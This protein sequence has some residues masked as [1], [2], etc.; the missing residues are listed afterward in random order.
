MDYDTKIDND[1]II[2]RQDLP[3]YES[4]RLTNCMKNYLISLYGKNKNVF[5]MGIGGGGDLGKYLHGNVKYLCGVEPSKKSIDSCNE[6]YNKLNPAR[7]YKVDFIHSTFEAMEISPSM[8]NNF[9]TV[10]SNFMFHYLMY[11]NENMDKVFEKINRLL[12]PGG[13]LVILTTD[14]KTI[15]DKSKNSNN[16]YFKIDKVKQLTSDIIEYNFSLEE[17]LSD[18]HEYATTI[19]NLSSIANK[20]KLH[21]VLERNTCDILAQIYSQQSEFIS[22]F[23]IPNPIDINKDDLELLSVYSVLIFQKRTV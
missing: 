19:E 22:K 1:R 9:D 20:H 13:Y 14:M 12:K 10:I 16:P 6:R 15:I 18:S 5:D 8:E 21:L 17:K 11:S 23:N 3:Y 4:L 2:I 7:R